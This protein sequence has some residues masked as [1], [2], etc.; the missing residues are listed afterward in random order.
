MSAGYTRTFEER[1]LA[2]HEAKA[3]VQGASR[4]AL[5]MVHLNAPGPTPAVEL[6]SYGDAPAGRAAFEYAAAG[7]GTRPDRRSRREQGL[8]A[9]RPGLPR[10]GRRRRSHPVP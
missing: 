8:L 9:R 10:G 4:G 1:G 7:T 3:V 5:D 6:T 2:N